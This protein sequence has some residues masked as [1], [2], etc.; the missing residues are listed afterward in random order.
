M[1]IFDLKDIYGED[2]CRPL[3]DEE[4]RFVDQKMKN[5]KIKAL[6]ELGFGV[7]EIAS[8][9]KIKSEKIKQI[10]EES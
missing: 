4:K 7:K 10:L 2:Y 9:M 1:M 5:A 3:T 6:Y 8:K